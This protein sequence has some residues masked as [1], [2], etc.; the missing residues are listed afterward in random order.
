MKTT[1]TTY[2]PVGAVV[3]DRYWG[4]VYTVLSHN[5]DGSV[6]VRWDGDHPASSDQWHSDPH[7]RG[8]VGTHFTPM[9]RKDKIL[10]AQSSRRMLDGQS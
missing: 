7:F 10:D 3:L 2:A 6:T 1:T 9:D 4:C 5:D 8:R